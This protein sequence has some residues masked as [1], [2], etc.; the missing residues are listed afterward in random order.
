MGTMSR[1][2]F[3]MLGYYLVAILFSTVFAATAFQR[4]C[5]FIRVKA[6]S[7]R[8][9]NSCELAFV[10]RKNKKNVRELEVCK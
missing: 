10:I 8:N 3:V 2:C 5:N 1:E 6:E 9:C 7:W 4:D